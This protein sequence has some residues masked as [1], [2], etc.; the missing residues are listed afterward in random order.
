MDKVLVG[1]P[2]TL[3]CTEEDRWGRPYKCPYRVEGFYGYMDG[4][5]WKKLVKFRNFKPSQRVIELLAQ[6][7]PDAVLICGEEVREAMGDFKST[8]VQFNIE[9]E[10]GDYR[11]SFVVF[12][13]PDVGPKRIVKSEMRLEADKMSMQAEADTLNSTNAWMNQS[14]PTLEELHEKDKKFFAERKQ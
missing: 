6:K 5:L 8:L 7:E 13:E 2:F 11:R 3:S 1:F 14:L 12:A 4:D 10:D 9:V